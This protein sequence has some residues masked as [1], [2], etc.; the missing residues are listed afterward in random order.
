MTKF[1]RNYLIGTALA[2][3]V[4][5]TLHVAIL[6]GGPDWYAFFGAPTGLVELARAGNLRAPVS[7]LV[8]AA[9]LA[10][11][12]AYAFSGAGLIRRLPLLRMGLALMAIMLIL[13]G[14]LFIPMIIWLPGSL[15]RICDCR[16][17]DLF[18]VL[19]SL[20]CLTMGIGYA[21]GACGTSAG[22]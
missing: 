12:A 9:I 3:S 13:R 21:L 15:S 5:S 1:A 20:L 2:A 11:L 14:V 17:V 19:T 4:G 16:S 6:F 10:V 18:I 7:C 8:I 22:K